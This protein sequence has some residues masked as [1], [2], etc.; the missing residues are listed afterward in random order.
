MTTLVTLEHY[1]D[2]S[3]CALDL[4]IKLPTTWFL[5]TITNLLLKG[6]FSKA[7]GIGCW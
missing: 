7:I 5:S 2:S 1:S 6:V 4:R 3:I